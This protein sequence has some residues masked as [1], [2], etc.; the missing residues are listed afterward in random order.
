[1][2]KFFILGL[3]AFSFN[4]FANVTTRIEYTNTINCLVANAASSSVYVESID[5]IVQTTV[6]QRV[7][8]RDCTSNCQVPAG[9]IAR[10]RGPSITNMVQA[11]Q[12]QVNYSY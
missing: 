2:K 11:A 8:T 5:Y 12:C 7:V 4:S 9:L 6:G 1:M 10:F 3:I